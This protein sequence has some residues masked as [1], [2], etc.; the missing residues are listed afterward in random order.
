[1]NKKVF[2]ISSI[3]HLLVAVFSVGY[4]QFD[5]HFQILEFAGLKLGFN[6]AEDLPWEFHSQIRSA[7]QPA[8]AYILIKAFSFLSLDNP[9]LLAALL[10]IISALLSVTCMYLLILSF[11]KEIKSSLLKKWLVFLSLFLWFL[12]YIHVRFSSENWAGF[13]FGIGLALL[14]LF[15]FQ[16]RVIRNAHLKKLLIGMILGL[17]FILRYQTGLM[18]AGLICWLIIIRKE[19]F[20]HL[21]SII[22]GILCT[23]LIGVIVDE[24]FY[25][26][27][28]MT[29][30]NYAGIALLEN[31]AS[32]F[33]VSPWWYFISEI[34]IKA[35]PP[36]SILIVIATIFIWFYYPKHVL[37]WITIPFILVH[38]IIGHKELRF[39]FPLVNIL[40][41]ILILS[42]QAIKEDLRFSKV[43]YV[44][45]RITDRWVIRSFLIMNSIFLIIVCFKPADSRI[46]LYQ[47]I[48]NNYDS[49]DT[50]VIYDKSDPY[51]R[52]GLDVNF[53]K[54]EK[55]KIIKLK[56]PGEIIDYIEGTDKTIL[57]ITDKIELDQKMESINC[58][59]VYQTLPPWLKCFNFNNW[60]ERTKIWVLYECTHLTSIKNSH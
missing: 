9:F 50:E 11:N 37:T 23:I 1:M 34:F 2:F 39:L 56:E 17:S 5:E 51:E 42:M 58:F 27:W 15:D 32:R 45:E 40:P 33:G 55:I 16:N 54:G 49:N 6:Q 20:S 41:L 29:A 36:F 26:E 48:Y 38:S 43:K 19:N 53:Y 14:N 13:T 21:F 28:T 24:W 3:I 4:H 18:I 7:I 52:V 35:L 22:F 10:R 44:L 12:P 46:Y 60:V 30:W 31:E 59:S 57:L 8:M 47:H 25:G